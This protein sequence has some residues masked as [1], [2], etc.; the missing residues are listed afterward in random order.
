MESENDVKIA[1]EQ[2][3]VV[4]SRSRVYRS[5]LALKGLYTFNAFLL[6]ISLLITAIPTV[7]LLCNFVKQSSG[8]VLQFIAGLGLS[9]FFAL[10]IANLSALVVN[11]VLIYLLALGVRK[12]WPI[13]TGVISFLTAFGQILILSSI[14]VFILI[15]AT[16]GQSVDELAILASFTRN[17]ASA[18]PVIIALIIIVQILVTVYILAFLLTGTGGVREALTKTPL[19]TLFP[20]G[21]LVEAARKNDVDSLMKLHYAKRRTVEPEKNSYELWRR[22][23]KRVDLERDVRV[24]RVDEDI[25][26]FLITSQSFQK[27]ES[28]HLDGGPFSNEAEECLLRDFIRLYSRSEQYVDFVEISSRDLKLQKALSQNGWEKSENIVGSKITGFHYGSAA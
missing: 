17:Q 13:L 4:R 14:A 2:Y 19:S 24:A 28:V 20:R 26:G 12:D 5:T 9:F 16:G 22:L 7:I 6:S 11:L 1:Q 3:R 8:S 15:V 25:V 23:M 10:T 18:N 27:V 21:V